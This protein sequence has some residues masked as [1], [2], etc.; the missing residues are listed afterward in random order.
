MRYVWFMSF[1]INCSRDF[2][3][4]IF[5]LF[6][7]TF[8]LLI[9]IFF[10]LLFVSHLNSSSNFIVFFFTSYHILNFKLFLLFYGCSSYSCLLDLRKLA[11]IFSFN[12]LL[13][14]PVLLQVFFFFPFLS[15]IMK[16]FIT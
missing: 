4:P 14:V 6:L 16:A 1:K 3:P 10:L 5:N 15:L 13:H 7:T 8:Y 9:L 12:F 2:L 11:V